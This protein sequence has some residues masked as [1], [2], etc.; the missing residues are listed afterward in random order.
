MKKSLDRFFSYWYFLSTKVSKLRKYYMDEK[1]AEQTN[2]Q[3]DESSQ[4]QTGEESSS[5]TLSDEP[6]E[7]SPQDEL[8]QALAKAQEFQ[9]LY[10]RKA[11]DFENYRKRMIR[12]KQ[13]A[14]DYAV[15]KLIGDLLP[16]M[17]NFDRALLAKGE[18][19]P[20]AFVDGV[21]MIRDQLSG[22]LER[23]YGL[24]S[25]DSKGKPFDPN[26]H[27]AVAQAPSAEV[28]VQTVGEEIVKGY[29]IK[30][31][32]LRHAKVLVLM[33]HTET[34]SVKTDDPPSET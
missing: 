5:D 2:N 29:T 13:E 8:A 24:S 17:D 18:E 32:V 10:L 30:D 28:S 1:D 21:M 33:P 7:V 14:G 25:Y 22:M 11:A 4:T 34:E 19:N 12:E 9:D 26:I 16:I 15:G 27:E 20:Q 31:K 23:D 3:P 6:C